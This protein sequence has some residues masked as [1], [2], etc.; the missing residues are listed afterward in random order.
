[1]SNLYR[2]TAVDRMSS[3]EQLDKMIVI[4][5]PAIWAAIIGG[6]FIVVAVLSWSFLGRI[7]DKVDVTGVF[8][9]DAGSCVVS[10]EAD[11]IISDVMVKSGDHVQ[12]N[13][14]LYIVKPSSDTY[15]QVKASCDGTVAGL[16]VSDGSSVSKGMQTM[17]IR[18]DGDKIECACYVAVP[19]AGKIRPGMDVNIYPS[20]YDRQQYGHL[21]GK[22]AR[23]N[24]VCSSETEISARIGDPSLAQAILSTGPVVEFTCELLP[25]ESTV[26]GYKWSTDNASGLTI[27]YGTTVTAEVISGEQRPIYLLFPYLNE[28]FE[29]VT[30]SEGAGDSPE[31][32][33]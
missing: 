9:S 16:V 27:S 2:K 6:A 15:V 5:S 18:R 29:N 19:D 26:S 25:D 13:D 22:V 12:V 11:G 21:V 31:G 20:N 1:M 10:S 7:P 28:K 14:I 33:Y 23:V 4:I 24:T 30:G 32:S 8:V 3:P 17:M